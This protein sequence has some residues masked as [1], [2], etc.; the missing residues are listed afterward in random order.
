MGWHWGILAASG[1][2]AAGA[3]EHLESV[4]LTGSQS[5]VTF[6][7]L[8]TYSATFR[9][10]QIRGVARTDRAGTA[11]DIITMI[12]NGDT[13]TNYSDHYLIGDGSGVSSS[14][15]TSQNNMEFA[16]AYGA[17]GTTN[18]FSPFVCDILDWS[19]TSKNKTIRTLS[20]QP[21]N[22]NQIGLY[23]GLW[24]STAAITSITLDQI[25][26]TNFVSGSRF[27]LYGIKG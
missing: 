8:G 3:Y 17:T 16:T 7:N 11:A 27:S 25:G 10:L 19:S 1:A 9:H 21:T 18:A 4:I 24:R 20:G 12:F 26:G 14:N 15:A 6:S 13:A 23:S 2:G 22:Y 5:T